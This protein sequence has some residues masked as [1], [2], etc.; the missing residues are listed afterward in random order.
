[1][2]KAAAA[3]QSLDASVCR[4]AI[5]QVQVEVICCQ[6][7]LHADSAERSLAS[8]EH[9]GVRF[10]VREVDAGA[11][12]ALDPLHEILT[13]RE[14]EIVRMVAAGLRNKQIAYELHLSEYTVAAYVKNI[15]YKLQVRNRTAMVTRC[16]QLGSA[17][18]AELAERACR[19]MRQSATPLNV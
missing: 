14:R 1:M 2:S 10:V 3:G 13:T 7:S 15:C 12:R 6:A 16:N 17:P 11:P 8:F 19:G 4:F 18:M 5:G 9:A